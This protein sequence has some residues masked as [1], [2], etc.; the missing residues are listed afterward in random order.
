MNCLLTFCLASA[1]ASVGCSALAGHS[2]TDVFFFCD[3]TTVT[4][5]SPNDAWTAGTY[6]LAVTM[7]GTSAQCTVQMPDP[8]P[9]G[10][11]QGN[12]GSSTNLTLALTTVDSVPPVVCSGGACEGMSAT[13]IPGHFQMTVGIQG[14]P[15][16]VGLALSLDGTTLMSE[17]IAPK[18]TTTEPNGEGCGTCTNASATVSVEGG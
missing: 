11:V 1:A 12:C 6:S 2:C 18:S 13:P 3:Q 16:E 10:G 9:T 7:D 4:L 17:S 15:T 8:P 5:Q 14:L